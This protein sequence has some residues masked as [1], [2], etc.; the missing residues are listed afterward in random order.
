MEEGQRVTN[1]RHFEAD[2]S[3]TDKKTEQLA[4][5]MNFNTTLP[6]ATDDNWSYVS[7]RRKCKF[8]ICRDEHMNLD[9]MILRDNTNKLH[10]KL[11]ATV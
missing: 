2:P 8:A 5:A 1:L 3:I 4:I 10:C 11:N 6:M 9:N 7:E